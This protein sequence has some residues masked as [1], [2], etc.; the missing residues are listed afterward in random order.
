MFHYHKIYFGIHEKA[1]TL[2]PKET[3]K[4]FKRYEQY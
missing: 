1:L 3:T 2:Q 4:Q